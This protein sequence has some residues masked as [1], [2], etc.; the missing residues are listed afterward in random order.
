MVAEVTALQVG[1]T[2]L[3]CC[4][5]LRPPAL[6][7]P[8]PPRACPPPRCCVMLSDPELSDPAVGPPCWTPVVGPRYRTSAVSPHFRTPL[9]NTTVGLL[10][11]PIAIPICMRHLCSRRES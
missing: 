11:E 7:H 5:T 9:S 8:T 10:C 4:R 2:G 1:V 6:P 3:R